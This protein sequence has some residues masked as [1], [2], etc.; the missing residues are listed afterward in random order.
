MDEMIPAWQKSSQMKRGDARVFGEDSGARR[1]LT[2][3]EAIAQ[4]EALWASKLSAEV[5]AAPEITM[6]EAAEML[7][8]A[9]LKSHVK[10]GYT[11]RQFSLYH[12]PFIVRITLGGVCDQFWNIGMHRDN[13][14]L[15]V[16]FDSNEEL[17]RFEAVAALTM[18]EPKQLALSLLRD[19]MNKFPKGD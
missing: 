9:T 12:V 15:C 18:F 16:Y 8:N 2:D 13:T 11:Y 7:E 1:K 3:E 19:F 17:K 14:R 10:P 6:E 5:D 4:F